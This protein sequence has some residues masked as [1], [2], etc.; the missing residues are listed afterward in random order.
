MYANNEIGTIEPI[1]EIAAITKERN[2][3]FHV[4]AVQATGAIELNLA[5]LGVDLVSLSAHKI[6]GPKGIGLLY[7]RR[8]TRVRPQYGGSQESGMRAGTSNVAGA[9]GFAEALSLLE[10]ER[11]RETK[12]IAAM[13]EKLT[14]RLLAEI[15]GCNINGS[16]ANRLP[17]NLNIT[18][19]GVDAELLIDTHPDLALSTGSACTSGRQDPS[20]VLMAIGMSRSDARSTLRISLGRTTRLADIDYA[21]SKIIAHTRESHPS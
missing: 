20:H 15:P 4:D 10:R 11:D 2:V 3:L 14:A 13:R 17:G 12:R 9:I 6:Y 16:A 8:G 18:L 7:I 21:A 1:P 5:E 19:P